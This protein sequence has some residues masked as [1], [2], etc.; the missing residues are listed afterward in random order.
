M[1]QT[2]KLSTTLRDFRIVFRA[3]WVNLILFF[4]LLLLS[5]LILQFTESHNP[6]AGILHLVVDCFHLAHHETIQLREGIASA[7]LAFLLPVLSMIILGEGALRVGMIYLNKSQRR[8]E[9]DR[10]IASTFSEHTV[11]CGMGELG[12]AIVGKI[13]SKNPNELL[14]IVDS[15]ADIISEL[16]AKGTNVCHIRGDMTTAATLRA[17][18][19]ASASRLML[20]SGNDAHNLEA[21]LKGMELNPSLQIWVRLYRRELTSLMKCA[22]LPNIHFFWPYDKAAE[23]LYDHSKRS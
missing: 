2:G 11:L 12:R 20:T 16:E 15:R 19:V 21:G 22:Q 10:M 7:A 4:L 6:D 23:E 18:K 3:I 9:W 17:A 14:V 13:L 1:A 5:A 8:E